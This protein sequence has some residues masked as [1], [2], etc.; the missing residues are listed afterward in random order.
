MKISL[1][2]NLLAF[3]VMTLGFFSPIASESLFYIGVFALS[4][5]LTNWLAIHMLFEK[6]PFFYGSGVIP[7][8]FLEFKLGLKDLIMKEF[9][10]EQNL[11]NFLKNNGSIDMPTVIDKIDQD[12]IFSKLIEAIEQSSLG[13]MLGMI[14]GKEALLPLKEPMISKLKESL[15]EISTSKNSIDNFKLDIKEKIESIINERLS[16]LTP[17]GVKIIIQNIIKK[18]L[19]WLV[20]WGAIIGSGIGFVFSLNQ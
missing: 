5:G 2:T 1:I 18:H 4:G 9:F 11:E 19:G 17:E 7:N 10:S 20:V 8:R 6:V 12:K 16:L 14:G 3:F 15:N 13:G